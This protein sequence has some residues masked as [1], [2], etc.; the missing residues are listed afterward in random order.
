MEYI[1]DDSG[2]F[3]QLWNLMNQLI[4]ESLILLHL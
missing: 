2:L 4:S 1:Q 3:H